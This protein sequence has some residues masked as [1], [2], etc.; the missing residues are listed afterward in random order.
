[1]SSAPLQLLVHTKSMRIE[2]LPGNC[3]SSV[4]RQMVKN[5]LAL[6]VNKLVEEELLT[7]PGSPCSSGSLDRSADD[8]LKPAVLKGVWE[9]PAAG[10]P[11][12][13]G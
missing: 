2:L 3:L 7:V 10:S 1:M 8:Q 9:V 13:V 11:Q 4:P 6:I 12:K 5:T